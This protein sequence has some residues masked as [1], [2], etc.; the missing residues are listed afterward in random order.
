MAQNMSADALALERLLEILASKWTLHILRELIKSE[1]GV[2][3]FGELR[4]QLHSISPKTL[5]DRLRTLE[6]QGIVSRTVFSEVPLHVEYRLTKRGQRLRPVFRAIKEWARSED[7]EP[8][9]RAVSEAP[10]LQI[11]AGKSG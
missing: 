7:A 11:P 9:Q 4:R 1:S 10:L 8:D 3:R 2:I 6:E 5:T